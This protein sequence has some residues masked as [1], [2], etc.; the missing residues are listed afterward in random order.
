[1]TATDKIHEQTLE[2]LRASEALCGVDE[3]ALR[4]L[5]DVSLVLVTHSRDQADRLTER[6]IRLREGR[7][8]T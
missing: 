1:V 8:A 7:V 4:G 3:D 2:L 6:T 5:H